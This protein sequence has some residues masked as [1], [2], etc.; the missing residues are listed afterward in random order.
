MDEYFALPAD[1]DAHLILTYRRLAIGAAPR[2]AVLFADYSAAI[3]PIDKQ[4]W[5][6]VE[7]SKAAAAQKPSGP[8]PAAEQREDR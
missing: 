6:L 7:I 1:A 8:R 2:A 5:D 3:M 4:F